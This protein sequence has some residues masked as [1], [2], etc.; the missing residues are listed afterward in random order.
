M[1]LTSLIGL[2]MGLSIMAYAVLS[3][4]GSLQSFF[5]VPSLVCVGGGMIAVVLLS[6]PARILAQAP[7]V[8][9]KACFGSDQDLSLLVTE[10]LGLAEVARREGLLAV[11]PRIP[12]VAD[13]FLARAVQLVVDGTRPEMVEEILRLDVELLQSRHREGKNLFDQ[14]GRYAPA[15]GMIGTL[16]GLIL[17][18]GNMSDPSRIGS[19]MAVALVTTLYGALAANLAF[20]PLGEKLAMMHRHEL[21]AREVVV[22]GVMAIQNGESPRAVSHRLASFLPPEARSE[23]PNDRIVARRVSEED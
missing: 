18:L 16:I 22:R 2:T 23:Q 13:P 15:F 21:L 14:L 7:Q 5:D 8:V 4:G 3:G 19:G 12:S 9:R 6:F 10:I 20:L 17:M 1:D 11:E